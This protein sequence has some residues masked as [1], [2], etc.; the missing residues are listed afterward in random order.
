MTACGG[1]LIIQRGEP[2]DSG[3]LA[4]ASGDVLLVSGCGQLHN[5]LAIVADLGNPAVGV[6]AGAQDI[7]SVVGSINEPAAG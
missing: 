3:T 6:N 5:A 4:E 7:M 2:D 1:T